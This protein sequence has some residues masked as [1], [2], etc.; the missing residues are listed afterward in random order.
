M[1]QTV[2]GVAPGM[3]PAQRTREMLTSAADLRRWI[4]ELGEHEV[5]IGKIKDTMLAVLNL[6]GEAL[7]I[8]EATL[9]DYIRHVL[10]RPGGAP[11]TTYTNEGGERVASVRVGAARDWV[12]QRLRVPV[13]TDG[14]E[15]RLGQCNADDCLQLQSAS[16]RKRD[17]IGAKGDWYGQLVELIQEHDVETVADLPRDVLTEVLVK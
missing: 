9:R 4:K 6:H 16:Y 8:A 12:A 11:A 17:E 3:I 7:V 2:N 1:S 10:T 14:W 5:D 15:K 13:Y